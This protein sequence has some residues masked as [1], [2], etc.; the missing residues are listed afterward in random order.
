L[1]RGKWEGGVFIVLGDVEAGENVNAK[2]AG[3]K[4]D[5]SK[6]FPNGVPKSMQEP[7][8]DINPLN[9]QASGGGINL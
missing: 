7:K 4:I 9:N 3:D 2:G 6:M 8:Q 5:I 1:K